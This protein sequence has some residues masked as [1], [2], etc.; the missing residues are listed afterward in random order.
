MKWTGFLWGSSC[1]DYWIDGAGYK[2]SENKFSEIIK[3]THELHNMCLEATDFAI[4]DDE[5]LQN[6]F[7]IPSDMIPMIRE[8]W[9]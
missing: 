9:R 5:I 1:D 4:A 3:T 7:N 6:V 8:S 2:V